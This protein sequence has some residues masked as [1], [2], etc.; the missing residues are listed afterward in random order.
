M[1]VAIGTEPGRSVA[2]AELGGAAD[3]RAVMLVFVDNAGVARVKCVPVERLESAARNGV[4]I[5]VVLGAFT[6]TDDFGAVPGFDAAVGDMRLVADL[7]SLRPVPATNGWG[8]VAVDQHDQAGN[9]WPGCQRGFLR[10]MMSRAGQLGF[11]LRCAFELE[12]WV[13]RREA[14]GR[15]TAGH[16]GPGYGAGLSADITRQLLRIVDDLRCAGVVI[17]QIHPEFGTG[18]LELSLPAKSPVQACDDAV[19]ARKVVRDAAE[20]HGMVAS[21]S[22]VPQ[23]RTPGNG[24]HAH[25][26]LW[27]GGNN[28]FHGGDGAY[29]LTREGEAFIA[30]VL[31]HLPGMTAI[32]APCRLSYERLKPS[33][34]AGAYAC[35]GCENREAA[36]RLEAVEGAAAAQS[37]NVEWKSVDMAAN[38]YLVQGVIVAAGLD[39]LKRGLA[40]P[41]PVT[42]NPGAI[43]DDARQANG[44]ERLPGDI[45]SAVEALADDAAL[46]EA[47]G[48]LLF[49]S[50]LASRRREIEASA[51][52][53]DEERIARYRGV[54]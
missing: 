46:R 42:V 54:F 40:L 1:S 32:G 39:G 5:S 22:P 36:L 18:Q 16:S 37:A 7:T 24:S 52:M 4:G 28:L 34:W 23:A 38:P 17:E 48:D 43:D 25:F 3:V 8:M 33:S 35:W 6:A 11:E 49:E 10:R 31:A 47:M 29:G 44:I 51:G 12:W 53:S 21:F 41:E 15:W 13:G 19:F 20:A 45:E 26:S 50:I 27:R 30:G 14:D 9:P 2:V